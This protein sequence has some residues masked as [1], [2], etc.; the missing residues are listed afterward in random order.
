LL[1]DPLRAA[2]IGVAARACMTASY[3]WN[4]QLAP[5]AGLMGR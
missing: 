1:N 5:L 4:A 2:K 3:S